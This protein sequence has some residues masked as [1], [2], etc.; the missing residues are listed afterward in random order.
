MAQAYPSHRPV[1]S[2]RQARAYASALLRRD[3]DRA[4]SKFII[5]AQGRTGSSLLVD[6]LNRSPSVRCDEEI[7]ARPV[8]LPTEWV[9]AHRGRHPGHTYGF[10]V[11]LYQ[12]TIDQALDDPGRWLA[13]MHRSGWQVVYLWRRNLLRHV[14]SNV[15]ASRSTRYHYRSAPATG[16]RALRI[17]LAETLQLMGARERMGEEE[18]VALEGIPHE[19]ACYED[20]LMRSERHQATL[21]RLGGALQLEPARATTAL[22]R[23]NSGP[24][25]GLIDNYR[26]LERALT[27]TPWEAYLD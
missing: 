22:R 23:I 26:E 19:T 7:L 15:A 27:G 11:K 16:R 2:T 10:K 5:F 4:G 3:P 13:A 24:L 1:P 12:L 18:R 14:L 9:A 6:L 20:D 17:D 25:T 21:D 8:L